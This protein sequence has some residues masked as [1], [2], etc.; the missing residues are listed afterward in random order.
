MGS[1]K[2]ETFVETPDTFHLFDL[3]LNP[4]FDPLSRLLQSTF[5]GRFGVERAEPFAVQAFQ[6][7]GQRGFAGGVHYSR[8][9]K[10]A[11]LQVSSHPLVFLGTTF[12][13]SRG[14]GEFRSRGVGVSA[15]VGRGAVCLLQGMRLP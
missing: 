9:S 12:S 15:F 7:C 3:R 14:I 10:L 13:K 5:A 4:A 1:C 2:C 8:Q 6:T 11:M